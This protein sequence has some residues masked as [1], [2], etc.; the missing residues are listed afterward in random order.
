[1]SNTVPYDSHII[2][3]KQ[4]IHEEE[5]IQNKLDKEISEL[6]PQILALMAAMCTASEQKIAGIQHIRELRKACFLA[7]QIPV[8]IIARIFRYIY[9]QKPPAFFLS[10]LCKQYFYPTQICSG[11]RRVAL[12]MP[13]LWSHVYIKRKENHMKH[14]GLLLNHIWSCSTA[15]RLSLPLNVLGLN[16]MTVPDLAPVSKLI[17]H[18]HKLD[19]TPPSLFIDKLL[20]SSREFILLQHLTIRYKE[21]NPV[22]VSVFA[23]APHISRLEI[24]SPYSGSDLTLMMFPWSRLQILDVQAWGASMNVLLTILSECSELTQLLTYIASDNPQ[25]PCGPSLATVPLL[26]RLV[27]TDSNPNFISEFIGL[28]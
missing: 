6:E 13:E 28:L 9:I 22:Q 19:I 23:N 10:P 12:A 21:K 15:R 11:W 14:I 18:L 4:L 20:E 3:L 27:V 8:E 2:Q 5:V 7:R 26:K 17:K 16:T 24:H 25:T 1:M